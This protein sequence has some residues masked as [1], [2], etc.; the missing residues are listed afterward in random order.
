MTWML[1]GSLPYRTSSRTFVSGVTRSWQIDK[2]KSATPTIFYCIKLLLKI[3][4]LST[5]TRTGDETKSDRNRNHM[6]AAPHTNQ[7]RWEIS[8]RSRL[9]SKVEWAQS[10]I[11]NR[12]WI[13]EKSTQTRECCRGL[14]RCWSKAL[15][16]R[17]WV[18]R[19]LTHFISKSE[20]EH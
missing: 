6:P 8:K 19:L 17:P 14:I 15:N 4:T 10:G 18:T 5:A 2:E 20:S 1:A 12:F 11:I 16:S 13:W 7:T 9:I 3:H